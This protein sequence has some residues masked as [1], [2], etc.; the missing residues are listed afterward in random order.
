MPDLLFWAIVRNFATLIYAGLTFFE[1]PNLPLVNNPNQDSTAQATEGS[2]GG[3]QIAPFVHR[4]ITFAPNAISIDRSGTQTV[5]MATRW[6]KNHPSARVVIVGQCDSSGSETCSEK[7]S[8]Q[9][10]EL[11]KQMLIRQGTRHEQIGA[12]LAWNTTDE[13]C[14]PRDWSCRSATRSARIYVAGPVH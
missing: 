5:C 1:L 11:V 9:R 10:A 7:L 13:R 8:R 3:E 14:R 2:D 6:L 12:V 4:P